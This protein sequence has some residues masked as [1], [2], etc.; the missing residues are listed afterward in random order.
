MKQYSNITLLLDPPRSGCDKAVLDKILEANKNTKTSINKIIYVSCNPQT[1]VRDLK[2][3]NKYY[4]IEELTPFDMF[5]NTHH[6]ECC[7]LLNK[8]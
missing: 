7:V 1:L 3:L 5:P 6:I 8:M 2:I 4:K